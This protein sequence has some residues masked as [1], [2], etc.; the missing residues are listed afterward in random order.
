MKELGPGFLERIYK[1]TLLITMKEKGLQLETEKPF[2]AFKT[3]ILRSILGQRR[4]HRHRLRLQFF[5][6]L[7]FVFHNKTHLPESYSA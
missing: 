3:W 1:N 4:A 5:D 6:F 2:N 7:H